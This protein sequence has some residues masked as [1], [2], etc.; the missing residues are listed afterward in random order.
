MSPAERMAAL[1]LMSAADRDATQ[2]STPE[3]RAQA[4]TDAEEAQA[5]QLRDEADSSLTSMAV[6]GRAPPNGNLACLVHSAHAK[7]GC[8]ATDALS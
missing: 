7:T 3:E 6:V 5:T 1:G 4:A 2:W 8:V